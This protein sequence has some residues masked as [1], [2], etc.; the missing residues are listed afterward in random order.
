MSFFSKIKDFFTN[1]THK[2]TSNQQAVTSLGG[3]VA[4][5]PPGQPQAAPSVPAPVPA[6]VAKVT[7]EVTVPA[8]VPAAARDPGLIYPGDPDYPTSGRYAGTGI[9]MPRPGYNPDD[10]HAV[11]VPPAPDAAKFAILKRIIRATSADERNAANMELFHAFGD[12]Q[13]EANK[14][15]NTYEVDAAQND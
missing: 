8:F 2:S 5:V 14:F 6:P 9:P 3:V 1:L 7:P 15:I 13:V 12:N 11:V 10:G 4:V